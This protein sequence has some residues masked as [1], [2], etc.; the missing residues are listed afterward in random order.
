[1]TPREGH[2]WWPYLLP[3]FAFLGVQ[4]LAARVPEAAQPFFLPLKVA[5]PLG[6]FLYYRLRGEYPELGGFRARWR[7]APLDLLVGVAGAALWMAPYLAFPSWRPGAE[8]AFDPGQLGP[9]LVWLTLALRCLGYAVV[10]PFV[11]ELFMRSWLLRYAEVFDRP[12]DFRDVPI[13]HYSLRSLVVMTLMFTVGHAPWEWPVAL[14]WVLG[15][16]ALFYH[17][18]HLMSLVLVHAASNLSIFVFVLIWTGRLRDASGQ[19]LDLWFFL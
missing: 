8:Q 19:P 2:G 18:K 10:T 3:F 16:Q 7:G 14:L 12:I 17:R 4:M 6:L 15:T 9:E 13:A 11:E 1:L 5:A